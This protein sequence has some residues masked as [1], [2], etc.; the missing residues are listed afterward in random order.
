MKNKNC[1]SFRN[2]KYREIFQPD[3]V[4]LANQIIEVCKFDT[5]YDIGCA[6]AF[7]L[8]TFYTNG[9]RIQ[10]IEISNNVTAFISAD[11]LE[12]INIGDFSKARGQWDLVC[13]IEVA[14]HLEANRSEELID[15]LTN[16]A[17]NQ[18]CFSAAP[19]SQPGIGH[20]NCQPHEY[21]INLF[22]ENNW[23]LDRI[24]TDLSRKYLVNRLK[25]AH[26][27]GTNIMFFHPK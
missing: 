10:G 21:W 17:I 23:V 11:I 22:Q 1:F 26:W 18:I 12:N 16:L 9:K 2:F 15:T 6:N 25:I 4:T 20:I 13:C 27:L 7:L 3:Y 19:P 14:E 24:K 5:V 8:H